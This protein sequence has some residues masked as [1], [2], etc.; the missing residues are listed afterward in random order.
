LVRHRTQRPRKPHSPGA[1]RRSPHTPTRSHRGAR[2]RQALLAG[3]ARVETRHI[4]CS[5]DDVAATGSVCSRRTHPSRA[6][7]VPAGHRLSSPLPLVSAQGGIQVAA[8]AAAGIGRRGRRGLGGGSGGDECAGAGRSD[9]LHRGR[10][11]RGARTAPHAP[12][13]A[14]RPRVTCSLAGSRRLPARSA[15]AST[16]CGRLRLPRR[17]TD[18]LPLP[19]TASSSRGAI[20]RARAIGL[21]ARVPSGFDEFCS[22]SLGRMCVPPRPSQAW[23]TANILTFNVYNLGVRDTAHACVLATSYYVVRFLARTDTAITFS[24]RRARVGT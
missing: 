8:G 20:G 17:V 16:P 10:R 18:E 3:A 23:P 24:C 9:P 19:R 5:I 13:W 14:C 12:I 4:W 21:A 22:R 1:P 6:R 2:R 15:C 11:Q 7:H